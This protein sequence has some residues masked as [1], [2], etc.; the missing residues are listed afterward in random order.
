MCVEDCDLCNYSST[1]LT[2]LIVVLTLTKSV[3]LIGDKYDRRSKISHVFFI[4]I[5]VCHVI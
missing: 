1:F 5:S 4:S 3:M 2:S